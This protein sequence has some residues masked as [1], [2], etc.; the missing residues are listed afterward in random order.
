[1]YNNGE[2]VPQ[3]YVQAKSWWEKG[4]EQGEVFAQMNLGNMYYIGKGVPQDYAQT[5][6]WYTKAAQKGNSKAQFNLATMYDEGKGVP[7][8]HKIAYILFNLAASKGYSDAV[9]NRD[10]AL[11]MLT[12][13]AREDAQRISTRLYNS[14]DFAADLRNLLNGQQ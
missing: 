4:A 3:N 8:N 7:Q 1:M 6:L 9:I 11:K 13:A 5:V 10:V 2:G 12:P 14:K